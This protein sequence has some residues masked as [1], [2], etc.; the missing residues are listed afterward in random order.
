MSADKKKQPL[1]ELIDQFDQSVLAKNYTLA[2]DLFSKLLLRIEGGKDAFGDTLRGLTPQSETEATILAS[3]I[4]NWLCDKEYRVTR[5]SYFLFTRYKRAISQ[6]FEVSGF[7]GTA[8]FIKRMG[9]SN[10]DGTVTLQ[11]HAIPKLFCGLSVNAVTDQLMDLLFRQSP[12][13]S[14]PVAAAFLSEQVVWHPQAE[15][16]RS[17]IFDNAALWNDIPVSDNIIQNLGPTYMGCSYAEAQNKHDIKKPMNA[18][19]RRWLK[20]HDITDVDFSD[21]ERRAVK[22]KP[23]LVIMA[24]LYDSVHAMHRCYGPAIRALKDRFKLVYMSLGGTCDPAIEYMFD[25]IDSTPFVTANPKPYFDKVKSY[26]PDVIYYPSVGM[27]G[28]SILGSNLRLAPIQVMTYGHP[29]TTH[30]D[31]IDYS[32]IVEGLIGSENTIADTILHWYAAQR[33]ELRPDT[34]FPPV[35][36]RPKPAVVRIAVP[37]WSRKITPRFLAVCQAIQEKSKRPVE[38]IF[39]PNGIGPLFQSFKRR[40]ESMLNAKVLP[41]TNYNDYLKSLSACDIFLSSF[42]FGATN[43]I[44]DAGPLGLPI[45]NLVGDEMH[46]MNDS[47]MVSHLKQPEWLSA[48][49]VKAYVQAVLKLIEDDATRVAISKANAAFDYDKGMMIEPGGTCE[50]FGLAVEAAYRHH[51][52]IQ[53]AGTKSWSCATLREMMEAGT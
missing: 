25:K 48:R 45:V 30:S 32:M 24:E 11:A 7:R 37:A 4:T 40:V 51:E 19:V 28:M 39:F 10:P 34:K 12:E 38:F 41:R 15:K 27:R 31:K 2:H 52:K 33:Y 53:A 8:H 43:G 46:A 17:R 22:R 5:Q 20:A 18:M 21:T 49:S 3:A 6:V 29:A 13:M 1:S 35:Q 42:P 14:W 9:T 44:L 23:T 36:I 47:E 16:A 26:R 50:S